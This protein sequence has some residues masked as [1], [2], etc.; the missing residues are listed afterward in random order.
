MGQA[1]ASTGGLGGTGRSSG[2]GTARGS[3]TP[4]GGLPAPKGERGAGADVATG[5]AAP[6]AAR[7]TR[8]MTVMIHRLIAGYA[9]LGLLPGVPALVQQAPLISLRWLVPTLVAHVVL[10][11]GMLLRAVVR[12]R[13]LGS[14][15]AAFALVTLL[16]VATLPAAVAPQPVPWQPWLW[17]HVGL[18]IVCAGVWGGV[19][20]S[21]AYGV[22]LGLCWTLLRVSSA[23]GHD[24]LRFAAA[25]ALFGVAAGL[26]ITVVALGMLTSAAT[27]DAVAARLYASQLRHAVDKAVGDERA[28]LDQLIHDDVLTT[29]ATAGHADGTETGRATAVLARETLAK[30]DA[31]Q[32]DGGREGAISLAVLA[33]LAEQTARRVSPAVTVA[34]DPVAVTSAL[35]LPVDVA[36]TLLGALREA[37]RNAVRH[38]KAHAVAVRLATGRQDGRRM[39]TV[40]VTDDG[41]GFDPDLV[42]P[43]RL[44]V[45]VSMLEATAQVGID[46]ELTTHAGRGTTFAMRWSEPEPVVVASPPE[47]QE[48]EEGLPVDFPARQFA[49]FAWLAVGTCLLIGLNEL[50]ARRQILP[51]LVAMAFV[52][53]GTVLALRPGRPLRLGRP[54][55]LLVVAAVAVGAATMD[56]ALP[57]DHWPD[58]VWHL[59]P[60]QLLLI[61]L[62]IRRRIGLA[63]VALVLF[64]SCLGWWSLHTAYGWSGLFSL[65]FGHVLFVA[66]AVLVDRVLRA[67]TR[68]Q[69][70]LRRQEDEAIDASVRSHIALVQRSLW[71]ADLRAQARTILVRLAALDG[72]APQAL[73]D[74]ALLV[75]ATLRESLVA[76]NVMSDE[77]AVLTEDARRRGVDVRFVDSRHSLVPL[78]VGQALLEA[79]RG[80]LASESVTRLVVR[81]APE[82]GLRPATVLAED[83]TGTR[84]V[85]LDREGVREAREVRA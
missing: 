31:L 69:A 6:A 20:V 75:E 59:F 52:V 51:V 33:D 62:V 4:D 9:V 18:A 57:R 53:G 38:A 61:V 27:A 30:I 34:V 68:R 71:V 81:L 76:R 17:W 43:A 48:V 36:E 83:E 2:A 26:V 54:S 67:I 84:I 65:G 29:L 12:A 15:A 32:T 58:A 82:D 13:P 16:A 37:V 3:G 40:A 70:V 49:G 22:A 45:R 72:A 55:A 77:L 47:Q 42:G 11:A 19:R 80:A 74:E 50:E 24:P 73:R 28:R 60:V 5:D 66:M 8:D 78:V 23:G 1:D 79:I 10:V 14:W 35:R 44:G 39:L 21:A 7:V 64:E 41:R 46:A 63:L 85:T 25:E 56:L